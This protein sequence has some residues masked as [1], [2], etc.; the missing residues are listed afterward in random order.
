MKTTCLIIAALSVTMISCS[1]DIR[2]NK[3]P[4]VVQNVVES[5][6]PTA[7][8]I[9]WEKKGD[10][11]EAEFDLQGQDHEVVIDASGKMIVHK[12]DVKD[13]EFPPAVSVAI[14]RDFAGFN[15]DDADKVER[16]GVD[17][18]QVALDGKSRKD[19]YVVYTKDGIIAKGVTYLK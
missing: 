9:E 15:I 12:T 1:Q 7:G 17:Y 16:D 19:E 18:Y 5:K 11:F 10:D 8:K 6:F 2:E 3:V 14:A 13:T 4:S